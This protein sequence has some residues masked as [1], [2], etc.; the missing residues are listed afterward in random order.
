MTQRV[1]S[2]DP[3]IDAAVSALRD[4]LLVGLPTETVYG[5][6]ADAT[7]DRALR[8]IFEVKGR[9]VDHPL[10]L[11]I[12]DRNDLPGIAD[13]VSEACRVLIEHGW[14]G[15]LTVVVRA[16]ATVS[17]VA[18][19]GQDTVAVRVPGHPVAR[20]I[21]RRLGRPV[22]APSANR[23]GHVSPTTADHVVSD[24][25]SD[26]A[27][28]VDGG[29]CAVGL[30]STIV[31]CTQESP[32]ILRPGA[33]TKEQID[34]LLNVK[35]AVIDSR[36]DGGVR[37]PGMLERHYAPVA[38]VILHESWATV[39]RDEGS[40]IDCSGDVVDAA[41]GLYARLREVDELNLTLVHVVLPAEAGL[42]VALR[43]RL[44]KAAAGR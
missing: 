19:G 42:G 12:A 28:V 44:R 13:G 29:A 34:R 9:P 32:R 26:V 21:I 3:G 38:R 22:A 17:R 7:N 20:E 16:R 37:A 24:L 39:P 27:V 2:D 15:P 1:E 11:H 8:R 33:V 6:A 5:L 41:K 4:G 35:G 31:D 10:I 25:G 23:F 36:G 14:P 18:T 40:V 43:D 30:E